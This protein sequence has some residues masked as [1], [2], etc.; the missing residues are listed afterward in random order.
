M[1]ATP[2]TMKMTTSKTQPCSPIVVGPGAVTEAVVCKIVPVLTLPWLRMALQVLCALRFDAA[3][4]SVVY[5]G[6]AVSARGEL[7]CLTRLRSLPL[8]LSQIT[9]ALSLFLTL[10]TLVNVSARSMRALRAPARPSHFQEACDVLRDG[11]TRLCRDCQRQIKV[12]Q[13]VR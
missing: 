6:L 2:K 4:G 9:L 8:T 7:A 13:G 10:L 11:K 1:M 3:S 5:C 12:T